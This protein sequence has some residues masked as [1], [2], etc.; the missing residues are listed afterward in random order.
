MP[1]KFSTQFV[2]LLRMRFFTLQRG[3]R[4]RC[5]RLRTEVSRSRIRAQAYRLRTGCIYSRDFGG[6]EAQRAWAPALACPSLPRSCD[7]MAV[8][9]KL[10]ARQMA[11][12]RSAL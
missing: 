1:T 10:M 4:S 11:A 8:Q 7:C 12:L 6:E 3:L 2:M 9:W 5:A